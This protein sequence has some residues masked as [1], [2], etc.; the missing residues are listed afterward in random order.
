LFYV[1]TRVKRFCE[2]QGSIALK[3]IGET[4]IETLKHY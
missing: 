4:I 3:D 1:I 2:V